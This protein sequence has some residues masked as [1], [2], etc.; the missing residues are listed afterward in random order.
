MVGLRG[1]VAGSARRLGGNVWSKQRFEAEISTGLEQ[2]LLGV[3]D[4]LVTFGETG[5]GVR[6]V[7]CSDLIH[8]QELTWPEI[9]LTA[10]CG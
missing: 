5:L 10:I 1:L 8:N 3:D 6:G 4:G 9:D 7:R 2:G